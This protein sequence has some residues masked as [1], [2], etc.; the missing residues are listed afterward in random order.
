MEGEK[1]L[2]RH[3]AKIKDDFSLKTIESRDRQF[4][5]EKL[6]HNIE[7]K[8]H[9]QNST[10]KNPQIIETIES[11]Y[12]VN[13]RVYQSLFPDIAEN[14]FEH[15]HSLDPDEIQEL[16]SGIKENG[17]GVESI[18]EI[19]NA[20][21]SLTIFP[22]FYYRNGRIPFNNGLIIVPD[23]EVP[24]VMEKINLKN[25]YQLFKETK[26]HGIVSLHFLCS[27]GIFFGLQ[28]SIRKDALIELY[29]NRSYGTLSG[30]KNHEF[31]SV[32]D[33]ISD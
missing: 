19:E 18:T 16:D 26:S 14:F 12:K 29:Q 25:L 23:G 28:P 4:L 11:N 33:L 32:S 10:E 17:W 1:L 5:I 9:Y 7:F 8:D 22:M 24:D 2:L 30:T 13:R 20:Q 21:H 15:I 27:L 6:I 31:E 3:T